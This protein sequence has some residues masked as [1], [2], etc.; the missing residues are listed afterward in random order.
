MLAE[1]EKA[2]ELR[3]RLEAWLKSVDAQLPVPNR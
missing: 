1:P 3:N 2:K